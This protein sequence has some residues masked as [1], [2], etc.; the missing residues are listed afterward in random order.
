MA[1]ESKLQ[2]SYTGV[3][4]GIKARLEQNR[5]GD[6][7]VCSGIITPIQLREALALQKATSQQ[8][9]NVLIQQRL[10]NQRTLHRT[11]A[12]QFGLRMMAA[13]FTILISF[14]GLTG[15]KSARAGTIKDIPSQLT[16]VID[17]NEAE[18]APV[19]YYPPIFG[20]SERRSTNLSPFTKWT[21]MFD[22]FNRAIAN[23]NAGYQ[24]QNWRASLAPFKGMPLKA[25]ASRVNEIVNSQPYIVDDRNWGRSDYWANPVEFFTRG[26]DCE[27]FAIAKYASLRM[28]GVPE[29][30]LRLAIVHDMVKDI[31]HAILIVYSD[32]GALVLDNQVSKVKRAD[33]VTRYKPIFSINRQ[34]WWLHTT[35]GKPASVIASASN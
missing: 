22:S 18:I 13:F 9:G 30:R 20:S 12:Q 33:R 26:G 7:L 24:I 11:L 25:M 3:L 4:S 2:A 23:G 10:I 19:N 17:S 14:S 27:D 15:V 29:E 8:L 21:G 35:T 16:L 28:L 31:P 5:L 1:A 34:A 32:E 6:L